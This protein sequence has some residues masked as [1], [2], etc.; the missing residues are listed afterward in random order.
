[1]SRHVQSNT[2]DLEINEQESQKK[3]VIIFSLVEQ[4]NHLS[5]KDLVVE[6]IQ[7]INPGTPLFTI[8]SQIRQAYSTSTSRP[9]LV[10]YSAK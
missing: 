6:A 4:Q 1:M 7:I 3:N 9:R 8:N 2:E 10:S 5:D